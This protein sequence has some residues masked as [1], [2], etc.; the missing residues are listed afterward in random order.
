[1]KKYGLIG[2]H[3]SH[4]FSLNYFN[5]K[6]KQEDLSNC[7]YANYEIKRSEDIPLFLAKSDCLG[8]NITIPYKESVLAFVNES[9][10][11]VDQIGACNTLKRI[12]D[13]VWRAYNTDVIG[14]RQS[15]E[16]LLNTKIK[17]ALILG[18]GGAAKAVKYALKQMKIG[19]SL[20]SRDPNLGLNYSD[21]SEEI[22]NEHL[23]IIH[24]TPLG[25]YP[26][27]DSFPALPYHLISPNHLL[28]DLV[29]NPELS[30]FLQKGKERG[31]SI[32]NGLE[33]LELQAEAS[34]KIW[35]E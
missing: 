5:N 22:I 27:T 4:S 35:N 1:M 24:T 23:L 11:Q 30:L 14:F 33:M 17:R 25:M 6:F 13:K 19:Y 16:P 7:N 34:W 29:Y 15:L 2:K 20:V 32:K 31:A 8:L 18:N 3:L 28:Y 12:G 9:T 21:I 10:E 26:N